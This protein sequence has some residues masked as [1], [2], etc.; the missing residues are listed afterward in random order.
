[1]DFTGGSMTLVL[2]LISLS[3]SYSDA[4]KA[5]VRRCVF[6]AFRVVI[7]LSRSAQ[8]RGGRWLGWCGAVVVVC[9]NGG[10]GV[11]LGQGEGGWP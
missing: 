11:G 3:M 2:K 10:G 5:G 8:C 6:C 9:E 4:F 1:M 7:V